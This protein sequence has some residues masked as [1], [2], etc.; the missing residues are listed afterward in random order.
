MDKEA[1]IDGVE[2]A[3]DYRLDISDA[4]YE[5]YKRAIRERK[6]EE[7]VYQGENTNTIDEGSMEGKRVNN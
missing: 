4:D 6:D 7:N 2:Y 3:L 1:L 5:E